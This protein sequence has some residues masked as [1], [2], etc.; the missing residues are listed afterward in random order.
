MNIATGGKGTRLLT[1]AAYAALFLAGVALAFPS[2]IRSAG[3]G[4][5]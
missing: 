4:Q 3:R 5:L 1:A 2:W